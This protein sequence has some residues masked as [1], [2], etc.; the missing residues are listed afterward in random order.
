MTYVRG[1][2]YLKEATRIMYKGWELTWTG[3]SAGGINTYVARKEGC[4]NIG[5]TSIDYLKKVINYEYGNKEED[6]ISS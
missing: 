6:T 1:N 5:A 3:S 2:K 4:K